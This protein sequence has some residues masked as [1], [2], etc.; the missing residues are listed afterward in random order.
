M[1]FGTF[2][3]ALALAFILEGLLPFI[4]PAF[5]RRVFTEIVKLGDHQIRFQGFVSLALGMALLWLAR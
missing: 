2:F 1:D 4:A 5:W 3:S